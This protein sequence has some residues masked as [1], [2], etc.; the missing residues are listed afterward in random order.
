MDL[1]LRPVV[2]RD[3]PIFFAQQTDPAGRRMVAFCQP[4]PGALADFLAK[5][6]S[7]LANETSHSRTIEI[8]G[9]VAGNVLYFEQMG[10]PS[11]GYWIGREFWGKGVATRAVAAFVAAIDQ[12]P[13]YARVASD[14]LGS[15]RVLQRC[16][17]TV[18]GTERD[19]AA[20]RAAEIDEFLLELSSK[21]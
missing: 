7:I 9:A 19:F 20:M 18:I 14:N 1:T 13:L 17:F 8:D 3:L 16:G 5:W 11:I 15:L 6:R 12:R 10:K 4:E 21:L 2:E